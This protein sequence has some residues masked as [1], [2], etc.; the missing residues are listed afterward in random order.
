M[1]NTISSSLTPAIVRDRTVTILQ[2]KLAFLKS[3]SS[4]FSTD[5]MAPNKVVNVAKATVGATGQTNATNFESG[6]STLSN[7][8]VTP[9]L[10]IHRSM[11][12]PVKPL[13]A[14]KPKRSTFVFSNRANFA[15]SDRK[16]VV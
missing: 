14:N 11:S 2:S 12:F 10:L 7:I 15:R 1:A 16:S 8:A 5:E 3:F 4:D 9:H 6:D 13:P